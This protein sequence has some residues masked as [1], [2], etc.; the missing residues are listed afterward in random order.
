MNVNFFRPFLPVFLVFQFSGKTFSQYVTVINDDFSD[1]LKYRDLTQKMTFGSYVL[2]VSGFKRMAKTDLNG[3]SFS[4]ITQTDSARKYAGYINPNSTKASLAFDYR[5]PEI[6]RTTDSIS[7]EFDVLW[8]QL[9]SGGNTGRIVVTLMDNLPESIP[10][11]SITDSIASLAPFGRPAY[12]FRILNRIPQGVNNY[13]NM[14]YGGGND[15][16]GEFEK[17]TSGNNRWWL[18][19]FISGPGG[20]SPESNI[21]EYPLGPVNR[22]RNYTLASATNWRHFTWKI[23]P[24]KLEVWTRSAALAAGNDTLVMRMVTPKQGPLPEMLSKL[25]LGHNLPTLPDSLPTLYHWFQKVNGVR[26]YLNGQNQTYFANISIKASFIPSSVN[27]VRKNKPGF[28]L[29]PNPGAAKLWISA[30]G[31]VK[32][33][34]IIDGRGKIVDTYEHLNNQS[35]LKINHLPSGIYTIRADQNGFISSRR[36]CKE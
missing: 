9:V 12:S 18:P 36:W 8:G 21:P 24:E 17:Y 25:Q 2:P 35:D 10:V 19:G 22:W 33:L 30:D 31:P 11:G 29:F 7:V 23:F 15:S 1:S 6:D 26:F 20:I 32:R 13:A 5:F 3:L 34:W 14:M 16:L 27:N 28:V 4:A